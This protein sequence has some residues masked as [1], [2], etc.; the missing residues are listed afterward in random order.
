MTEQTPPIHR[1]LAQIALKVGGQY[2][3]AL[4]GGHAIAAHGIL[5]RP[6]EDVDLFAD[7]QRRADFPTAVDEVIAA[8]RAEGFRVDIDLRLDTFA[9]LHVTEP[10][11]PDQQHRVELVANWRAQPPV[12]MDI[13]PVLHPDDVM[14]GKMDAL[15]NRAAAR[16]FLDI[17]AAISS[18]RY[19]L[20]QLCDLAHAAD[21]GFD[22]SMFA[23]MLRHV[24]RFDDEDFTDYGLAPHEVADMRARV[25]TWRTALLREVG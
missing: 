20:D 16:D 15:Y 4:A 3:F 14:A 17:D 8:Y 7:W 2:G 12:Q 23:A 1:R 19:T 5:D 10:A 9:R 22:R 13:G 18:G 25:S 6:S 11:H 24:D 21:D